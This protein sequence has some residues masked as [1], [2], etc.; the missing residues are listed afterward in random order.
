V[1]VLWVA[2]RCD[3]ATA[4]AREA[5]RADRVPGMAAS[6]ATV[7]HAGVSYDLEVDTTQAESLACARA[8]A[9]VVS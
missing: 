1:T 9:A 2:V 3:S 6:Q 8:I 5:A 4:A 7:V